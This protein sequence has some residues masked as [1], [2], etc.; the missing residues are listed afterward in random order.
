M[1]PGERQV[2]PDLTGIRRDHRARYHWAAAELPSGSRVIDCACGVGYGA[3]ILAVAG[4]TVLAIDNDAEALAYGRQHYAH[5]NITW[6]QSDAATLTL[7]GRFDAAICFET[8]EHLADPLPMLREFRRVTD[9]LLASVPNE[10]VFPFKGYAYHHRHYTRPEF[11]ALLRAAGWEP[12]AWHGQAGPESEVEPE[13]EGRT[14]IVAAK[15]AEERT[16]GPRLVEG[17]PPE[18]VAIVGLGPSCVQFF[19]VTRRLGGVRA[20]ADEV[21]GVNA[22]GGVL[23]CDRVFHMDD[24]V[25]QEARAAADPK[26]NIAPMVEWLKRHPGPVYTSVVRPG[27]PGLIAFP[28]EAVLGAGWPA[29]FNSTA[30]YAIAFAVHIGVK[31]ISLWG[32]DYTFPNVHE[33][34]RGRACCEF[35]LGLAAAKGIEITVPDG[36]TLMDACAPDR[37]KLYG[38][39]M[40]DVHV[41]DQEGGGVSV[42]FTDR[43]DP[44]TAAD[45]E[46][47][48]S[49]KQHVNRL[50]AAAE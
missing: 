49:H 37:E 22:I 12:D 50:L 45:I 28:L 15:R 35:W 8:V 9:R 13:L 10:K 5:P 39:D 48:Y 40:V 17:E 6:R 30:A 3:F 34:E 14:L 46:K 20:Y 21:W 18:H 11:F 44:P 33:G 4:H 1:R 38:Y 47:A 27:Y 43:P 24:L 36:S 19:E 16:V 31:H 32:L 7:G 23:Q 25:V 42:H 29:Y 41:I 26:G 2:A